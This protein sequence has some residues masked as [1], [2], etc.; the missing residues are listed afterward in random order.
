MVVPT[1]YKWGGIGYGDLSKSTRRIGTEER[2]CFTGNK[3]AGL[4][5]GSKHI[6]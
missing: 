6:F 4:S 1:R 2:M 5:A 3:K